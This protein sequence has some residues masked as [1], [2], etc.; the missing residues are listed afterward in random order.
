[1]GDPAGKADLLRLAF[2]RDAITDARHD[3]AGCAA[4]AGLDGLRLDGFVLAVN[5]IMTNAVRHGG[6]QGEIHLWRTAA[7]LTCVIHDSGNGAPAA[8][9]NG[10]ELPPTSAVGGRGLWLARHMCD[11]LRV[12][13]GSSGTSVH[14]TMSI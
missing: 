8:R 12:E 7:G 2:D 1:V 5:E 10:H 9:F 4:S 3:V 13:S 6:G 14:M 11:T